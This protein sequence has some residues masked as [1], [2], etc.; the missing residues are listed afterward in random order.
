[1]R[2]AA[3]FA[4]LMREDRPYVIAKWAQTLDGRLVTSP[5]ADRW[6]SGEESRRFV[7]RL[8][9][10]VDAV[11]VGVN[12]V[13]HDD[14]L[15]TARDVVVKRPCA[16]IVLDR[17]LR[18]PLSCQLAR[19]AR[20]QPTIVLCGPVAAAMGKAERLRQRGVEV[21]AI[22][23]KR[24]GVDVGRCLRALAK[25]SMTNV[26]VEGGPTLLSAFLREKLVDDAYV[27][28]APRLAAE[29]STRR[30][31]GR[32]PVR[33]EEAV[34]PIAVRQFRSGVDTCFNLQLTDPTRLWVR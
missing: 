33:I 25:R 5:A 19:T 2:L 32:K 10:R 11:L 24:S 34:R 12:T 17:R 6:I 30:D 8:R 18:I 15:L 9:A 22:A 20:E 23:T 1:M 27:F 14:P 28:V 26:L 31:R 21:I 13:I 7:H 29:T 4:T 16:R 3:P